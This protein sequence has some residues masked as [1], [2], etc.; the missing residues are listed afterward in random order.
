MVDWRW[1]A[2]VATRPRVFATHDLGTCCCAA[3]AKYQDR[4]V[5]FVYVYDI[6]ELL[7]MLTC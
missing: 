7:G 6:H 3:A 5:L 1:A 4:S 2:E